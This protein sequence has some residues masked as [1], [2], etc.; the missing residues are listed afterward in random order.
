MNQPPGKTKI[1]MFITG[2]HF[3]LNFTTKHTSGVKIVNEKERCHC[4]NYKPSFLSTSHWVRLLQFLLMVEHKWPLRYV[5]RSCTKY[6]IVIWDGGIL[7]Y[8][9]RSML[10]IL[11]SEETCIIFFIAKWFEIEPDGLRLKQIEEPLFLFDRC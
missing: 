2:K 9:K 1:K 3:A 11:I 4:L 5:N 8:S 7:S 6:C 10:T